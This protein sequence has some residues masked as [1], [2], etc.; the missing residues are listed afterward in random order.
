VTIIADGNDTGGGG[1][2]DT[3]T[4][5]LLAQ[6]TINGA[7][8]VQ[9]GNKWAPIP[10]DHTLTHVM[11]GIGTAP[12]GSSLIVD[13]NRRSSGSVT[14][15]RATI[16]AG[17]GGVQHE[18]FSSADGDEG[19]S[20]APDVDQVGSSVAGSDLTISLWGVPR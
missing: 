7:V 1:G 16:T 5:R 3:T 2:S 14:S 9:T 15:S 8:T 13:I 20:Y 18:T 11:L 12:T 4:P 6:W 19:D 17:S 10:F